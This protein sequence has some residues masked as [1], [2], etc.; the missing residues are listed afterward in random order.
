MWC[1]V[2]WRWDGPSLVWY[3]MVWNGMVQVSRVKFESYT[4]LEEKPAT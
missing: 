2:A 1:G 3:D 4:S